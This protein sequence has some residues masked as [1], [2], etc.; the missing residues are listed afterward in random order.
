M[1]KFDEKYDEIHRIIANQAGVKMRMNSHKGNIED[2]DPE[3][4]LDKMEEEL[5]E[6]RQAIKKGDM[7][8]ILEE[9][10]DVFNFLVALVHQQ[11]TLY[12]MRK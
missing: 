4:L 10:G 3:H 6:L 1:D 5:D 12:R 7:M 11:V 2:C 8:N 9:S